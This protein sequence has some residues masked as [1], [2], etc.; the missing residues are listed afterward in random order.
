MKETGQY[1][2]P[3]RLSGPKS[4]KNHPAAFKKE[5]RASIKALGSVKGTSS[6]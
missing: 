1:K 6:S 5:N 2:I 4:L 3:Q